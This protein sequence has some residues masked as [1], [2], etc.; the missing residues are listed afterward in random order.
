VRFAFE[1]PRALARYVARKGSIAVDGVSL[2]VNGIEGR[3]FE[4][5]IVPHTLEKTILDACRPGTKVNIEVDLIARYL[6]RLMGLG[7]DPA[8]EGS[9]PERIA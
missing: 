4:V 1:L 2:T 9:G 3:R 8:P 5:N 6:E 7:G